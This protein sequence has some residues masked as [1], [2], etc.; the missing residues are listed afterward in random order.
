MDDAPRILIVDDEIP[1]M[2]AL[3]DTL[4]DRGYDTTGFNRGDRA[5]QEMAERRF[6]LLLTDLM[7]PEMDG[8]ALLQA[9]LRTDPDL[10]GII[11][12]GAGTIAS[13]VEAM[14]AGALDYIL[15]P[16]KISEIVPVLSRSLAVR[17][18]R[19][20][21]RELSARVRERTAELEIVNKELK[22]FSYSISHDL[23]A[24]LRIING[25]TGMLLEEHS[26]GMAPEGKALLGDVIRHTDRMGR[27]VVDLL[28]FSELGRQALHMQPVDIL[29][30]VREV[31]EEQKLLHPGRVI[32]VAIADLP[33]CFGDPSLIRQVFTNVLSNAFKFTRNIARAA[34]TVGFRVQG[35]QHV[36]FVQDNGV[37]FAA[38]DAERLF[39]V[40]K[41]LHSQEDFEGSGIGMTIAHRIV[42]RHGGR[43]WAE[44]APRVGACFF[45][46]LP[47]HEAPST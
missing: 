9:A 10:V 4:R 6:D 12:T 14:K 38:K 40:F 26:A 19:I 45:I 36:Y 33:G 30:I 34:I 21:N 46:S 17:S 32:D 5:L 22:T 23:A 13:A 47:A 27:L 1:Q 28:R 31:V 44:A 42:D 2:T 29:A 24:P 18:L 35:P 20:E 25:F 41:R 15:K 7:M 8:I 43:I 3:C 11:M 37:G 16:F 39:Q